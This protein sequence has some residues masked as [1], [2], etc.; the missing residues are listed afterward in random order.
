MEFSVQIRPKEHAAYGG[1]RVG[2]QQPQALLERV[3][4]VDLAVCAEDDDAA[5][6]GKK[7]NPPVR[8]KEKRKKK[9][10]KKSYV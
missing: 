7:K 1:Q 10:E 8:E 2:L 9:K 5:G 4:H 6:T 3:V